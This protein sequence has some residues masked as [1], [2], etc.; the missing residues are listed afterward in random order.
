[1]IGRSEGNLIFKD[2]PYICARHASL[3]YRDGELYIKDEDSIN[4]IYLRITESKTLKPGMTFIAGEQLFIIQSHMDLLNHPLVDRLS[5]ISD[6]HF[7]ANSAPQASPYFLVQ[8]LEGGGVGS[9]Y[10]FIDS[11]IT[12]GRQGCD[13]NA[14]LDRFMSSK[15]CHLGLMMDQQ[16]TLTDTGSKNGT[17]LKIDGERKLT[18]G[19]YILVGKQL[20]QVQPHQPGSSSQIAV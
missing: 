18:V 19:D 3:Y 2:D 10:P 11:S 4:G 12:I 1:M 6:V 5:S 17:Y 7:F 9:I 15:H 16:V 20:L 13:I 14:P 8:L